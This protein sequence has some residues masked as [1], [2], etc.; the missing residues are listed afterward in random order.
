[1]SHS[2][3]E[4]IRLLSSGEID[5]QRW[6]A[7]VQNDP[8]AL[9]YS[10][11]L[12][13]D[14]MAEEWMGIVCE[15]YRAVM[16]LPVKRK[17][18]LKMIYMPPF[19]QRLGIAGTFSEA[20]GRRM[21]SL[22]RSFSKVISYAASSGDMFGSPFCRRTNYV[23]SLS[24]SYENISARY[25]TACRKN[26]SKAKNRGCIIT[27]SVMLTDV[28]R[29]YREAYGSSSSYTD[30]H[31]SRLKKLAEAALATGGCHISG[32]KDAGGE[33]VYAGLLINDGKRLYYLLGA[34]SVKGR[35]MRATYFFLDSIIQTFSGAG[36][37]LD[38]EGS[39]IPSVAEFYRSFA[40]EM[41]HYHQFFLNSL[42]FPFNKLVNLRVRP[43]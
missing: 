24:E 15:D 9:V 11:V 12:F 38:F 19:I 31:F 20:E 14:H 17:A 18:G 41:E 26:L 5:R 7:C 3:K 27:S 30:E 35:E 10:S 39:D 25:T 1:M 40:P 6:D 13:L 4:N 29:F 16:P 23:L 36:M 33:L 43:Q 8:S 42:P 28:F 21:V 32:V 37:I 34:P 2:A 22:A